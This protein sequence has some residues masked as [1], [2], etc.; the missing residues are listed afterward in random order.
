MVSNTN[1]QVLSTVICIGHQLCVM[2]THFVFSIQQ[3]SQG[4]KKGVLPV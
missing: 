4:I 3:C 1:Y 2:L